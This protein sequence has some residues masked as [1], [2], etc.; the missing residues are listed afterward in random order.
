MTELN[1]EQDVSRPNAGRVFSSF[2]GQHDWPDLTAHLIFWP[3]LIIGL[4]ADLLTKSLIFKWL[5][6]GE[7][8]SFINGFFQLTAVQNAGA[9]FGMAHGQ[10]VLLIT[11]SAVA[12]VVILGIFFLGGIKQRLAQIA[13]GLFTAGVLGNLYDRIFNDGLVR[14]FIDITYWPGKHWPAFNLADS[15][16]CIAVG[17][18]IITSLHTT[19]KQ[20]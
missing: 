2:S 8:Y 1:K 15:M 7:S 11:V 14:D 20:T 13:L 17:L 6:I 16:L 18:L 12:S 9:A 10:R 19:D 5:H 3:I 4:I